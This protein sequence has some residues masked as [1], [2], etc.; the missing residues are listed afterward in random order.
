[1]A[2]KKKSAN[3]KEAA[4]PARAKKQTIS[5]APSKARKV[6]AKKAP[7]KTAAGGGRRRGGAAT[8]SLSTADAAQIVIKVLNDFS[9]V[10]FGSGTSLTAMGINTNGRWDALAGKIHDEIS[11]FSLSG[12]SLRK[13][14][15]DPPGDTVGKLIKV[16]KA[17]S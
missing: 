9:D 7:P 11:S 5:R 6:S 17:N 15:G 10:P 1:M 3:K 13:A 4:K 2:I 16:V 8:R 14:M 12:R